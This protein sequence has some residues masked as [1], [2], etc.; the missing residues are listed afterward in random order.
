[1]TNKVAARLQSIAAMASMPFLGARRTGALLGRIP[2]YPVPVS[3]FEAERFPPPVVFDKPNPTG[4]PSG[5]HWD[6]ES[7]FPHTNNSFARIPGGSADHN[8]F[9][10]D[11]NDRPVHGASH[12]RRQMLKYRWRMRR[13]GVKTEYMAHGRPPFEVSGKL[14]VVTASI[15]HQFY[16]W[17]FDILPRLH[18]SRTYDPST[19]KYYI[20]KRHP[21]QA[22][23]LDMLGIK[24]T[25]IVNTEDHPWVTAEELLVPCHQITRGYRHPV[26]VTDWLRDTFIPLAEKTTEGLPKRIYISRSAARNRRLLNE[27]VLWPRFEERGFE[28]IVTEGMPFARQVALFSGAEAVSGPH[29][30]GLANIVFCAPGT[31]VLELFPSHTMDCYYRLCDDLGLEYVYAK[32]RDE[33]SHRRVGEDFVIAEEDLAM[34]FNHLRL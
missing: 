7:P 25:D 5:S 34:A 33:P 24:D 9:V 11:R 30:A 27:D 19:D 28:R 21:F 2:Y 23:T 16:H 13:D 1:M 3:R 14:S 29:G 8:G 6:A 20:Q 18:K 31:K 15:H 4:F 26:W 22:E 32:T 10:F 17:L 12:P